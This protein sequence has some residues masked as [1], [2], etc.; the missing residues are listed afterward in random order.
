LEGKEA[1]HGKRMGL[2]KTTFSWTFHRLPRVFSISLLLMLL[3]FFLFVFPFL[4]YVLVPRLTGLS[5]RTGA[6]FWGLLGKPLLATTDK[7]G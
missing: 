7:E 2:L 1:G 3:V 6:P 5:Y 4:S